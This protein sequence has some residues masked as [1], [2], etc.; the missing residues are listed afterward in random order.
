MKIIV[1]PDNYE[2]TDKMVDNCQ[3]YVIVSEDK[4]SFTIERCPALSNTRL[5]MK[6]KGYKRH[7]SRLKSILL[8]K[9]KGK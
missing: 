9:K 2:I 3:G 4:K 8:A 7:I 5:F 1:F 6:H